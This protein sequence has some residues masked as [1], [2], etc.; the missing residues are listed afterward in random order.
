[1][2]DVLQLHLRV[3]DLVVEAAARWLYRLR[4]QEM[5][6]P[7][8]GNA[9]RAVTEAV[10]W[11]AALLPRHWLDHHEVGGAAAWLLGVLLRRHCATFTDVSPPPPP[12]RAP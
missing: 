6:D 4:P 7:K 3:A 12:A 5:T 2:H 1:M 11:A 9:R 8:T 10:R